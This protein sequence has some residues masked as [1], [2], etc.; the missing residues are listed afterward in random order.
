M[1]AA[2]RTI[3]F[4]NGF[5]ADADQVARHVQRI[6]QESHFAVRV[7]MPV[8]GHFADGI[9]KMLCQ[10][11]HLHVKGPALNGLQRKEM[12]GGFGAEA[13]EA[14]LR[15]LQAGQ[16]HELDEAVEHAPDEMAVSRFPDALRAGRFARTDGDVAIFQNGRDEMVHFL[17]GHGEVG[18]A[19]EAVLSLRGQHAGLHR[20][21]LAAFFDVQR[22]KEGILLCEIL[23]D[24]I[25]AVAAAVLH[26]QHFGAVSLPG[27]KTGDLFQTARQAR[28]FVIRGNDDGEEG[29]VHAKGY[30]TSNG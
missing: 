10:E 4:A 3:F 29:L 27:E 19:D 7:E 28:L 2:L 24:G 8:D 30:Y 15:I 9:A 22:A 12:C 13:L 11:E 20:N 18:I 25:G 21:A 16:R 17:D 5:P 26:D 6:A 23:G 1:G 14:A